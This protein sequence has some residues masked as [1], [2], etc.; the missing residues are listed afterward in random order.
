MEGIL[1][2]PEEY[3]YQSII[4]L[5]KYVTAFGQKTVEQEEKF[6]LL[7]EV[8]AAISP[9]GKS[10]LEQK[11]LGIEK[12]SKDLEVAI[13]QVKRLLP[14]IPFESNAD[15]MQD[16]PRPYMYRSYRLHPQSRSENT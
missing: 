14:I 6:K 12:L 10:L 1:M 15:T 11:G 9:E 5:G 3:T 7:A 4:N 16:L 8:L 13:A 2:K